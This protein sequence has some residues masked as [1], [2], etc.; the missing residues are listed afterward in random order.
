MRKEGGNIKPVRKIF[1]NGTT[2]RH[3]WGEPLPVARGEKQWKA[4]RRMPTRGNRG[5]GLRKKRIPV[6]LR[7]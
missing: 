6:G 3:D 2:K 7:T 5:K 1:S 4:S